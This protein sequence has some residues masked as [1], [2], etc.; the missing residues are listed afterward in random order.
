MGFTYTPNLN[1]AKPDK[2][3]A[4]DSWF[5]EINSNF[6][7]IDD[8]LHDG[9][10]DVIF[11]TVQVIIDD[12][13]DTGSALMKLFQDNVTSNKGRWAAASRWASDEDKAN[14]GF[15]NYGQAQDIFKLYADINAGFFT[16]NPDFR[17]VTEMV[18]FEDCT[19][20]PSGAPSGG[21]ILFADSGD[22]YAL[23]AGGT[24]VKLS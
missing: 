14:L 20:T 13:G 11:N 15:Y 19:T 1:L 10:L 5:D 9:T 18:F 22:L 7:K 2:G 23:G 8:Q 4:G 21:A 24:P 16:N 12:S 3:E 17:G 6:D